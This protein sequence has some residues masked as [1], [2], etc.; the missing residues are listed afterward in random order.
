MATLVL[1]TVGRIFGGPLGGIFGSALGGFIDRGILGGGGKPREVGRVGNLAVQSAAYGE[2]IPFIAGRMRAAGNLLWT[3]GIRESTARSGGGK[4]GG[5]ATTSYSYSASFAVGLAGREIAGVARIWADGKL[6]RDA[7]GGFLSPVTMRL[8]PG[9]EIQEVDPLIAAAEGDGGAPAYRGIAYAVFEDMPLADFGNRIPNLTFEIV[10]DDLVN[11]DA[12]AT[13]A[14]IATVEG[15]SMV[16]VDGRFPAIAGY[17]G[18]RGGSVADAIDSLVDMSGAAVVYDGGLRVQG[19]SN[20]VSVLSPSDLQAR[21][22]SGDGRLDRRKRSGESGVA[23]AVEIAFYDTSRDFQPGL[24]RSRRGAGGGGTDHQS[25]ACAM[26]PAQAKTL[27]TTMLARA[28]AARLRMTVRLPW[29]FLSLRPGAQV[30]VEGDDS[31]WRVREAR[32]E[33]FV[34]HLDLERIEADVPPNLSSEGGRPL[35]FDDQPVG[36]TSL[37]LLDLPLLPGEMPDTPR[38]WVAAAGASAGWRRAAIEMSAD[39][40]SSYRWIGVAEGSVVQ[41]VA[42]SALPPGPKDAWDRFASIEVDLLSEAMWLEGCTAAAVIA[43]GNLAMIGSE[44]VQFSDAVQVGPRRFRLSGFLRG[45]RGTEPAIIGHV[46]GERFIMLDTM[47][48]VA[49]D[50]PVEAIG[51]MFRFRAGGAGDVAPAAISIVAGGRALRP[52]SPAHLTLRAEAG[53]IHANWTRRSRTGFGWQDFVDAPLGEAAEAYLV[54]IALDGRPARSVTVSAPLY[55]YGP[56]D[57]MADGGGSEVT[58]NISQLSAAVGPGE[59]SSR[60]MILD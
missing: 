56:A 27:A 50:P 19:R 11:G 9:S 35:T 10:A 18:G 39:D 26:T 38:L 41:G 22:A 25:L 60:T 37:Q 8:H 58:F 40:G 13:I 28:Q 51:R 32:F 43:G 1:G 48:M 21:S 20:A 34:L 23:E 16:T 4:R 6:I 12:G 46:A 30:A 17:F 5:P 14:A 15:R 7:G 57:R 55:A 33:A 2:P 54:E 29:R 44:I 52:L 53:V 24:Q 36:V 59:P 3:A 49:F 42:V 47:T 45:R 31:V